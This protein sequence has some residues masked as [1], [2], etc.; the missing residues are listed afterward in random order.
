MNLFFG[1]IMVK[2]TRKMVLED[3]EDIKKFVEVK[4]G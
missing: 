3:L 1:G 4:V 2:S